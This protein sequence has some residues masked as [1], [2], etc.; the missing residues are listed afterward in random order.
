MI[1]NLLQIT[2]AKLLQITTKFYYK[3]QQLI[4]YKLQQ[5]YYKLWQLLQT[6]TSS[7]QIRTA[8][9]NYDDYYKLRQNRHALK[10]I[11]FLKNKVSYEKSALDFLCCNILGFH[12]FSSNI[13][14]SFSKKKLYQR[15]FTECVLFFC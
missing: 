4:Y 13:A 6:A 8:I 12:T 11:T 15:H 3:L 2:T 1:K 9:T 10:T 7:L 14:Y 5:F